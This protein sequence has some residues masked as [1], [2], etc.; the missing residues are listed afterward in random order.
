VLDSQVALQ[1][2]AFAQTTPSTDASPNN[3]LFQT[4]TIRQP[5]RSIRLSVSYDF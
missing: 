2:Y 4:V 1:R 3:P 5:P